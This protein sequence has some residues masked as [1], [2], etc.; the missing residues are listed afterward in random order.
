MGFKQI[1]LSSPLRS[2]KNSIFNVFSAQRIAKSPL[3]IFI[4]LSRANLQIPREEPQNFIRYQKFKV[5]IL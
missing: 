4:Q 5:R 1:L 2:A 3:H